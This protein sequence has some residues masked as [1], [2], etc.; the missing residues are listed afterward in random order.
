LALSLK[1]AIELSDL[2]ECADL[3]IRITG[4][5][6][7]NQRP[8]RSDPLN[9]P[10]ALTVEQHV[11]GKPALRREKPLMFAPPVCKTPVPFAFIEGESLI[12]LVESPLE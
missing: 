7:L 3:L 4:L 10:E 12:D 11:F 1:E 8:S 6:N 5:S 9:E 2:L